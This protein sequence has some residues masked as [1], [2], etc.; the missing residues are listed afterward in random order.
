MEGVNN[1]IAPDNVRIG[2]DGELTV[3]PCPLRTTR[4]H[5]L[6]VPEPGM[7]WND[8]AFRERVYK[9]IQRPGS[10]HDDVKEVCPLSPNVR[11]PQHYFKRFCV[12][13]YSCVSTKT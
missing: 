1:I 10:L 7:E 8:E 5:Y 3:Q 13:F 11:R 9:L 12:W 2:T 6:G 4:T